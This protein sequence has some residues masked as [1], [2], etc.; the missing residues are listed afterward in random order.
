[1]K[2]LVLFFLHFCSCSPIVCIFLMFLYSYYFILQ[3]RLRVSY[4]PFNEGHKLSANQN[5][6]FRSLEKDSLR[7]IKLN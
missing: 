2:V 7:Q 4:F 3:L 1:M 6:F 5:Y